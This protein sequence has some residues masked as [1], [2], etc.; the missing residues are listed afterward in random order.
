MERKNC[1]ADARVSYAVLTPAGR[2]KLKQARRSHVARSASTSA[3]RLSDEELAT[4]ASLLARLESDDSGRSMHGRMTEPDPRRWKAL[5]VLSIAYLM[6][7]LDIA[8]VNVALQ[9]I[10]EDLNFSSTENLQWIVSGYA[11]TFGGFLLLGGR[12]GDVLGR[13]R[14]FMVGLALF[15]ATSLLAGLSTSSA[16]LI[17]ARVAQGAAGA[18]LS[19]SVFSITSVTFQE[20]SERNKALGVLGAISGAGAAIGVILGGVLTTYLTWRWIFFVNVP[21][22]LGTLFFVPRLVR[23]SRAEGMARKFDSIGA[24]LVTGGLMLFVYALTRTNQVGWSSAETILEFIG[25]ALLIGAFILWES[26]SEYALVPLSIFRRRTLTGANI[27]GLMLGT[28]VFGMFFLLSLYMQQVLGFTPLKTG[29]GYLAVALTAV[30]ASG[31]AQALVTKTG[32]KPALLARSRARGRR[33]RPTSRRSRPN[34]SYFTDLF[35][36]FIILGIGL[37]FTFVP[38]SI[39]ALAGVT[40]RDAGLASGLINT[41]QQIGGALGL[42]ILTTVATSHITKLAPDGN[43]TAG[44]L[45]LG[46]RPCVLGGHGRRGGGDRDDAADRA[47]ERSGHGRGR[48]RGD[49]ARR[50]ASL[51]NSQ[52]GASFD[53]PFYGKLHKLWR[54]AQAGSSLRFCSCSPGRSDGAGRFQRVCAA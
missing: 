44:R 12:L 16:M 14:V 48:G 22:G 32:V 13:R 45:D 34:G 18:I 41:S 4:L 47:E 9:S 31:A 35:P 5:A 43:P 52:V 30:V 27:I 20:G 6:V 17:G 36:G 1:A 54:S 28:M 11:L 39:A 29:I 33:P 42:A 21:I 2:E 53:A 51:S 19:P 46:L 26:K 25:S 24:V 10:N 37:G 3:A 49:C 38:I 50:L 7:V 8:I 15:A 23:E 40:G